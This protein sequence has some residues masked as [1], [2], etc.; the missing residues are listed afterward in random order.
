MEPGHTDATKRIIAPA[1]QS[2]TSKCVSECLVTHSTTLVTKHY[3][4]C[5][6]RVVQI[7]SRKC[8]QNLQCIQKPRNVFW[9]ANCRTFCDFT[10][11][12]LC[13]NFTHTYCQL[14]HCRV[15]IFTILHSLSCGFWRCYLFSYAV[16]LRCFKPNDWFWSLR[17]IPLNWR[18][19]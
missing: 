1:T 16:W 13:K 2:V 8:R 6:V 14:H 12:D 4:S 7:I 5:R 15:F 18:G 3:N 11:N 10:S 17:I 19:W 9:L